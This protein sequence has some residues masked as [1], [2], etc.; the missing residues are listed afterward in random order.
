[1]QLGLNMN[2]AP[3]IIW[4]L[5]FPKTGT[6]TFQAALSHNIGLLTDLTVMPKGSNT[7]KLRKRFIR[8]WGS[9]FEKNR[10][11][12]K[13]A[14]PAALLRNAVRKVIAQVVDAGRPTAIISDENL[15]GLIRLFEGNNI[16]AAAVDVVKILDEASP[17]VSS[18]FVFYTRNFT[19]WLESAHNQV[20]KQRRVALD[21]NSWKSEIGVAQDWAPHME[22]ITSA[23]SRPVHF[24]D[25]DA[26][27]KSGKQPG[28]TVLELAG[29]P[30]SVI[31]KLEWP[32]QKN[33]SLSAG[34]LQIML[35]INKSNL[36]EDGVKI[37]RRVVMRNP[38][39][40]R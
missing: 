18:E 10:D 5:G 9:H 12:N 29:V 22:A 39:A 31:G 16:F 20:I 27:L 6:T 36:D 40:F 14:V 33:E 17:D 4:H 2:V 34:A 32:K 13:S 19:R 7:E 24:I 11:P 21:F 8:H 3:R 35:Q 30:D 28:Q 15:I 26:E 1:M 25:F 38:E 23:T 37:V